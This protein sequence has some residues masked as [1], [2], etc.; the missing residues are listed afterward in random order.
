VLTHN[1]IAGNQI[2]DFIETI[3]IDGYGRVADNSGT[4]A[5]LGKRPIQ[6]ARRLFVKDPPVT[7]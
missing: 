6:I 7:K 1:R 2:E 4:T 5:K 3:V